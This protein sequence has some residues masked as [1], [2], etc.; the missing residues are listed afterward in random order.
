MIKETRT[1]HYDAELAI[2]AYW[3]QNVLEPFPDHFHALPDRGFIEKGRAELDFAADRNTSPP[4]ATCSPSTPRAARLLPYDGKPVQ[5]LGYRRCVIA[6]CARPWGNHGAGHPAAVPGAHP[7]QSELALLR[8]PYAMIVQGRQ[9]VPEGRN[10]LMLGQLLRDNAGETPLPDAYK[11][12]S[13]IG[14][15]CA[16]LEEHSASWFSLISSRGRG[17]GKG[18]PPALVQAEAGISP[19]RYLETIRIAK[20]RKLLERNVPMI[21]VAL[22]RA[23]WTRATFPA[24]SAAHR[25]HAPA[26]RGNL[27]RQASMKNET[28]LGHADPHDHHHLGH[29]LRFRQRYPLRRSLH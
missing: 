18:L 15:V 10:L 20:A 26:I 29:D 8:D 9:G 13:D 27:R 3:L 21:E 6:S 25:G 28:A 24:S 4:K 19:Y 23:L 7:E 17:L 14:A 5:L 16:Y 1:I 2:E 12:E 11:D 22:Q